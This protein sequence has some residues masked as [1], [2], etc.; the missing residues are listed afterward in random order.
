MARVDLR[1]VQNK[2]GTVYDA[3]KLTYIFAEDHLGTKTAIQDGTAGINTEQVEVGGTLVI[4][5][6]GVVQNG[7]GVFSYKDKK[8]GINCSGSDGDANRILTLTNT[9][10]TRNV[11]VMVSG[12][13][14]VED[15]DYTASHLAASSTIT[16]LNYLANDQYIEVIFFS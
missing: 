9:S 1:I 4:D 14:L 10:L 8:Q 13:F 16:F 15:Q 6:S 11:I 2:A 12:T 5:S 3:A 7:A